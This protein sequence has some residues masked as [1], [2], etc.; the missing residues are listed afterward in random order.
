MGK[1]R[2]LIICSTNLRLDIRVRRQAAAFR[3]FAEVTTLS[4]GPSGFEHRSVRLSGFEGGIIGKAVKLLTIGVMQDRAVYWERESRKIFH[5]NRIMIGS[6]DIIMINELELMPMARFIKADFNLPIIW[7]IHEFYPRNFENSRL[8]M[9]IYTRYSTRLCDDVKDY[10]DRAVTVSEG[11]AEVYRKEFDLDCLVIPNKADFYPAEAS[12]VKS[13][14][15]FIYHGTANKARSLDLLVR[16]FSRT[17]ANVELTLMLVG[18]NANQA[19]LRKLAAGCPKIV[20]R[21]PVESDRIIEV[22]QEYDVGIAFFPP[23]TVNLRYVLPN[24][25]FEYVQARLAVLIGPSECMTDIVRTFDIGMITRDFSENA[26][27]DVLNGTTVENI[28]RLKRNTNAAA[29]ELAFDP[30]D[31]VRTAEELL[32][33]S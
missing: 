11:I 5:E 31:Y 4:L 27:V 2:I 18:N 25:F 32:S 29:A 22:S 9:L 15:R 20:F 28:G 23:L 6:Q 8:W 10:A 13:P 33:V 16:A 3:S 14:V 26:V 7:D 30:N 21:N 12:P 24:K 1:P 19:N 17:T